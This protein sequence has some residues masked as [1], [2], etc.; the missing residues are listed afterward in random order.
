MKIS[1]WI[2]WGA[3]LGLAACAPATRV[4]LLPQTDG[5]RTAVGVQSQREHIELNQ[6]YATA[7]LEQGQTLLVERSSAEQVQARYGALL[8]ATP[9]QTQHYTLH[10]ES[11]GTQ[12]TPESE[13]DINVVLALALEQPGS[14][15]I[16][17]GHTDQ[18]GGQA[19]NDQLSLERARAVRELLIERG[20]DPRRIEAVGR[21]SRDLLISRA[22]GSSEPRNRRTDILIR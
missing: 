10:F 21:G 14:E 11:G 20:F 16:I 8:A 5:S 6:P 17:I 12:F 19:L 9:P 15:I 4:I 2:V 1:P 22:D 7:R 3:T 18:T 13:N